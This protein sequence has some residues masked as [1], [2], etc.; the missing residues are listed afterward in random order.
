[1]IDGQED[2]GVSSVMYLRGVLS[3]MMSRR[4]GGCR[5]SCISVSTICSLCRSVE[6]ALICDLL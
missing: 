3:V 4:I 1:M 5:P 2:R 6:H